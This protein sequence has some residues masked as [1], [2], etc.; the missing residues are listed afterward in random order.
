MIDNCNQVEDK[1]SVFFLENYS[2]IRKYAYRLLKSECDAEDVAQ[3]VFIKLWEQ[4][5]IWVNNERKLDAYL[6]VMTRNISLNILKHRRIKQ[7]YQDRFFQEFTSYELT[8]NDNFLADIYRREMLQN[9]YIVLE[10]VPERRRSIFKLSRFKG[11]SHKE[12]ASK[13]NISIHTVERHIYLTQIKLRE[14][15]LLV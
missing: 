12:I 2:K 8:N 15:L 14:V 13:M 7:E 3:E 10:T 11:K 9:I 5:E 6:L 4:Q 1:F